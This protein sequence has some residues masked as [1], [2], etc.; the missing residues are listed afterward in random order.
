ML[1]LATT[2]IW[3]ERAGCTI[4]YRLLR[5]CQ[6][7]VPTLHIDLVQASSIDTNQLAPPKH[8]KIV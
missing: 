4:C 1:K 3:Q 2:S 8:L 7:H 6:Y 5:S